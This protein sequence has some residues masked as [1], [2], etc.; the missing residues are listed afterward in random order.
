MP[1]F[2]NPYKIETVPALSFPT[3]TG[4]VG[5]SG[6]SDKMG[7]R[8]TGTINLAQAASYT[9]Y[10]TASDGAKLYIDNTLRVDNDGLHGIQER[11]ASVSLSAGAHDVRVDYYEETGT[12][13]LKLEIAG[14]GITRVEIPASMWASPGI[15]IAYYQFDSSI[16][17]PLAA[18]VPEKTQSITTI[19]YPFSWGAFA[20]SGRTQ[21]V[22]A[23]FEGFLTVPADNVYFFEVTSEDGSRFYIDDFLVVDNDGYHNRVALTGGRALRSGPHR[24]RLEYFARD[25]GCALQIQ[26]W[27]SSLSKQ[28][29]PASWGSH[30]PTLHVPTDYA[31]IG[32]AVSA[33]AAN[34]MVWVAAGTYTGAGNKNLDLGGKN[35]A[36]VSGGGPAL[37]TLDAQNSGR[38]FNFVNHAQSGAVIDG[39]TLSRASNT[40]TG[41]GG[42]MAFG[43]ST[44]TVRNCYIEGNTST[45]PGGALGFTGNSAPTFESCVLSGNHSNVGGGA[46][47][48]D[49]GSHPV[50]V[51]CTVSGN[52][53]GSYGG[54]AI[55]SNGG[56]I[57]ID[58]SILW[59]NYAN[60]DGTEAWT[61]DGASMVEFSCSDVR[62][63][64]VGGGGSEVFGPNTIISDPLFCVPAPGSQAPTTAGGYR[65]LGSSP[66]LTAGGACGSQ[67]G[68]RG[69]GCVTSVTAVDATPG[70]RATALEQNAPNPFNPETV[71]HF[72]LERGGRTSLRIFDV[73]GRL[74]TTLVD[75]DLPAG[76]QRI[77]WRGRDGQGRPVATGVYFYVLR[78]GTEILTRSMV[79]LK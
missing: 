42:A 64:G 46:I 54:G 62:S 56:Q 27:S 12:A 79:L 65:V 23:V 4:P 25:G 6:L 28:I 20:G 15:Q 8:C 53:A 49:A 41:A 17:P 76:P 32:A 37:T 18:M 7:A 11:S 16:M 55:A 22:A 52:F 67:I 39:F 75:R 21:D 50:F 70:Y 63:P 77:T 24:F 47:A 14:G 5:E 69:A 72:S 71:I 10:L 13:G 3:T 48:A 74:V 35:I 34:S 19:N 45:G 60:T 68:A 30:V 36:L 58:R 40:T 29:V 44:L 9:F 31:T 51:N 2:A 1:A 59:G 78:S 73:A 66:V 57:T 33:A 61:A 38:L 43:N 26:V